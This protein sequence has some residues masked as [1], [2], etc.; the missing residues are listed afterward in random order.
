MRK[1]LR[2]ILET[3]DGTPVVYGSQQKGQSLVE[4]ALVTPLLVI[5]L[6]GLAEIGYFAQNYL[7]LLEVS[8]VGARTGTVQQ[9][10][11]DPLFWEVMAAE[12]PALNRVPTTLDTIASYRNC[13]P[14]DERA[15]I[16]FYN[17]LACI[18]IRSMDPLP[19]RDP[20]NEILAAASPNSPPAPPANGIDDIVISAFAVQTVIPNTL[21]ALANQVDWPLNDEDVVAFDTPRSADIPQTIVVGRYPSG[22]NECEEILERDPF[23]WIQDGELTSAMWNGQEYFLE[24]RALTRQGTPVEPPQLR[25]YDTGRDE[26]QRGFTWN[27]Q[28]LVSGTENCIGS[29]WSIKRVERL[30]NLQGFNLHE[31]S[32]FWGGGNDL[33]P[34]VPSQGIILVELHWQ[35]HTLSQYVGLGAALSPVFAILGEETTISVWSAFPLPTVEPRIRFPS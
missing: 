19:F 25:G 14:D 27:G 24:L 10:Q 6:A 22:A 35:H 3:L 16:G 21:G 11:T 18:M 20:V 30:V 13:N 34:Y 33:R 9:G 15:V 5:L 7:T 17:F 28:H 1:M 4:L 32:E 31:G 29:E 26:N 2:K 23:D 12:N 8:R